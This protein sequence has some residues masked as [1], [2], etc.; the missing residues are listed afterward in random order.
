M[1]INCSHIHT[2][3]LSVGP[4]GKVWVK[5]EGADWP[6]GE[7]HTRKLAEFYPPLWG[8]RY[9]EPMN[10]ELDRFWME[11]RWWVGWDLPPDDLRAKWTAEGKKNPRAVREVAGP[12]EAIAWLL[13]EAVE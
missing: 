5:L 12:E 1:P 13:S 8:Q 11:G 4:D 6:D 3:I 2:T 7:R 10:T 9:G